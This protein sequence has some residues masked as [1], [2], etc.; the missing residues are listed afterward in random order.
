MLFSPFFTSLLFVVVI[1]ARCSAIIPEIMLHHH[2][3]IIKVTEHIGLAFLCCS[4][5]K[6]ILG[7]TLDSGV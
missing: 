2:Y 7:M 3:Y 5:T 6:Q 4:S 1:W